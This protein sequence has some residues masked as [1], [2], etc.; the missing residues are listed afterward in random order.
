MQARGRFDGGGRQER[1]LRPWPHRPPPVTHEAMQRMRMRLGGV[2]LEPVR[3]GVVLDDGGHATVV[4]ALA[5]MRQYE[6][7]AEGRERD[8][9]QRSEWSAASPE[10]G[11]HSGSSVASRIE[12]C[13]DGIVRGVTVWIGIEV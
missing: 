6:R 10:P 11:Q 4:V 5:R 13:Q 7:A 8:E 2:R 9:Q 3:R 12:R 1:C